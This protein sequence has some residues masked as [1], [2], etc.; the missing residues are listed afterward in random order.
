[1][2]RAGAS[3]GAFA[4][5]GPGKSSGMSTA[6][7]SLA[8]AKRPMTRSRTRDRNVAA[9]ACSRDVRLV[10]LAGRC[11]NSGPVTTFQPQFLNYTRHSGQRQRS[12]VLR[13]DTVIRSGVGRVKGHCWTRRLPSQFCRSVAGPASS[14]S[15]RPSRTSA[16]ACLSWGLIHLARMMQKTPARSTHAASLFR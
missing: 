14:E 5:S 15:R 16:A 7:K 9:V 12:G 8:Q 2:G 13:N 10:P 3:G 11:L 4:C 6:S 1:M